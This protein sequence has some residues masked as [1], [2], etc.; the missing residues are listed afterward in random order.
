MAALGSR[1]SLVRCTSWEDLL[2]VMSGGTVEGCLLDADHPSP[3]EGI[4]RVGRLRAQHPELALIAFTDRTE[5]I[6][7][8]RLGAAGLEGFI[9]ATDGPLATQAAVERA[10][11][12]RRGRAVTRAL[13]AWIPGPG[14][15]A[16]GWAVADADDEPTVERM[17]TALG[18]S[19]HALRKELRTAA[20]PPPSALLLW[21]RLT[22]VAFRLAWDGRPGEETAFALGYASPPSLA[23]AT[24]TH[25]GVPPSTVAGLGPGEVL[26][27]LVG[28]ILKAPARIRLQPDLATPA[29]RPSS[30]SEGSSRP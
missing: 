29:H 7:Y 15:A 1:H 21:G 6:D 28:R 26:S 23:R 19:L 8:Y 11:A 13:E 4:R 12:L 5:P 14:P 18:R 9:S 22:A 30:P 3:D 20:L 2:A 10:L 16:L 25:L 27:A 24:R 17:A